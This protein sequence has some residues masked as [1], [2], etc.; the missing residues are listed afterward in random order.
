MGK[1]FRKIFGRKKKLSNEEL[2]NF[3]SSTDFV[4]GLNNN[5]MGSDMYYT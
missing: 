4:R 3:D 1:V 2:R 5:S